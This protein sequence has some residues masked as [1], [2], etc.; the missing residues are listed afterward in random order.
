MGLSSNLLGNPH[1]EWFLLSFNSHL[2]LLEYGIANRRGHS[3]LE[4][5]FYCDLLNRR[6]R[7]R[8]YI[9]CDLISRLLRWDNLGIWNSKVLR[10]NYNRFN[11]RMDS[12]CSFICLINYRHRRFRFLRLVYLSSLYASDWSSHWFLPAQEVL[13]LCHSLIFNSLESTL[14]LEFRHLWFLKLFTKH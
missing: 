6:A 10:R 1:R 2:I 11:S 8:G 7:Y 9:S 13:I 12:S 4:F 14:V 3:L 5:P